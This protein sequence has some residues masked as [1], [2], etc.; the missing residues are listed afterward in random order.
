MAPFARTRPRP[1]TPLRQSTGPRKGTSVIATPLAHFGVRRLAAAFGEAACRG[2]TLPASPGHP[3]CPLP[4]PDRPR[5]G[6]QR[7]PHV[8]APPAAPAA[9]P[10]PAALPGRHRTD[11]TRAASG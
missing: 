9:L 8:T 2:F 1:G 11:P 3:S 6:P 7:P 5:R 10:P 4:V